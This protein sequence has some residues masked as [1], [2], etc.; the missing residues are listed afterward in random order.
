VTKPITQIILPYINILLVKTKNYK[1][2]ETGTES[3]QKEVA[4]EI[5]AW[6]GR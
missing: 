3:L 4:S 1:Q 5:K 6:M 2:V